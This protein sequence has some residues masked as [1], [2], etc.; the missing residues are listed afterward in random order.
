MSEETN[1][2][3]IQIP[4]SA[5]F[6]AKRNTG[7]TVLAEYLANQLLDEEKVDNVFVFSKTCKLGDNWK[8]IPDKYKT[9]N[10]DIDKIKKLIEHQKKSIQSKSKKTRDII[11]V[12]DDAIESSEGAPP[13]D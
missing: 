5:V 11:I 3:L 10:M 4:F 8:S 2:D 1:I 9:D 7:K 6:L 13:A 12:F